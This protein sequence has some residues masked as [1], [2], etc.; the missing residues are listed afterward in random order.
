MVDANNRWLW[1][2]NP[3]R[4]EAE[5]LRDSVLFCVERPTCKCMVQ[6]FKILIIKKSMLRSNEYKVQ[7]DPKLW[8]RTIYRF[9]VRTTPQPFLSAL[10][11]PDPASLTPKRN[12]TTTAVQALAMWNNSF[13]LQQAKVLAQQIEYEVGIDSGKQV[14]RAFY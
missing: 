1:R 6:A 5:T 2:Q 11:C 10:D 8:R 7:D 14:D 9:R 4:V 12:V 13:V 3:R